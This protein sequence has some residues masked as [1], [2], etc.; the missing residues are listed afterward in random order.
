M[1]VLWRYASGVSALEGLSLVAGLMVLEALESEGVKGLS[2]KWPNDVVAGNDKLAGILL[3]MGGDPAGECHVVL[4]IGVNMDMPV[5]AGK[6][7]DQRWTDAARVAG[8]PLSRNRLAGAIISR[9]LPALARYDEQGF[10]IYQERWVKRDACAGRPIRLLIGDSV[11][12]GC[13]AGVDSKGAFRLQTEGAI[14]LFHGG[15]VSLRVDA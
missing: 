3:E 8:G 13:G 4:G 1:S 6:S 10:A 2:L 12:R 5:E 11:Y 9:I 15:E 14:Q 7:I